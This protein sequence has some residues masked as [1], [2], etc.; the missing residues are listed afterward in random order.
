MFAPGNQYA[1]TLPWRA[2]REGIYRK[3]PNQWGH[4][5]SLPSEYPSDPADDK[6]LPCDGP[7]DAAK[8]TLNVCSYKSLRVPLQYGRTCPLERCDSRAS[9]R[10]SSSRG[11]QV[12]RQIGLRPGPDLF[13]KWQAAIQTTILPSICPRAMRQPRVRSCF[14]FCSTTASS[15]SSSLLIVR[16]K[17]P[18]RPGHIDRRALDDCGF[19]SEWHLGFT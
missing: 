10:T 2:D 5:T 13:S 4:R 8:T 9:R 18:S 12:E 7:M 15:S 16:A 3:N 11:R 17:R 19:G 14:C 6:S 1:D